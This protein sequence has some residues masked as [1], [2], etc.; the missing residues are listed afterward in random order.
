MAS[1]LGSVGGGV[2]EEGTDCAS[3][4]LALQSSLPM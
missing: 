3:L 2:N 1:S 4:Q